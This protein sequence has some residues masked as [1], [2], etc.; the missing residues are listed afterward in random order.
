MEQNYVLIKICLTV[1]AVLYAKKATGED[2]ET[3]E[4]DNPD[5]CPLEDEVDD[6][7]E[8]EVV[9]D[10]DGDP[11]FAEVGIAETIEK[12][13]KIT[14]WFRRSPKMTDR[15]RKFTLEDENIKE[16]KVLLRDCRTR[17]NS[18]CISIERFL[19]IRKV[20][21]TFQWAKFF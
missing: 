8:F 17:W 13:R 18:L 2:E 20:F 14:R 3:V 4:E 10:P 9:E 12:V 11:D 16:E 5:D 6:E 7:G 1:C 19:D 21:Y 15:L